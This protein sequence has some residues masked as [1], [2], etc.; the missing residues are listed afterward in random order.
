MSHTLTTAK[1]VICYDVTLKT[2]HSSSK[3]DYSVSNNITMVKNSA[4]SSIALAAINIFFIKIS[5]QTHH[6]KRMLFKD[7]N[8]KTQ[9]STILEN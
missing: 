4:L 7:N 3:Y 5:F 8:L 1:V 9:D 2:S 6:G